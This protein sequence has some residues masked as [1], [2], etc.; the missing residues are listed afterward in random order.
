MPE[1]VDLLKRARSLFCFFPVRQ[2][3]FEVQVLSLENRAL[4]FGNGADFWSPT[5][6]SEV[7]KLL[8]RKAQ[9]TYFRRFSGK[10]CLM[11]LVVKNV[12]FFKSPKAVCLDL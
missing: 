5:L 6:K 7:V 8:L 4:K 1:H 11:P 2:L 3:S 12:F 10:T 9:Q